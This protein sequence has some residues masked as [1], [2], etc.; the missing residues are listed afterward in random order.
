[1]CMS[2]QRLEACGHLEIDG[3]AKTGVQDQTGLLKQT[4]MEEQTSVQ[5][6]V[7][8]QEQTGV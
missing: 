8:M 7:G 6:Q 5:V 1:M 3:C 4:G 2:R